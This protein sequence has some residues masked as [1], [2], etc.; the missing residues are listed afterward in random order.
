[1][2]RANTSAANQACKASMLPTSVISSPFDALNYKVYDVGSS[3]NKPYLFCKY[4]CFTS[5]FSVPY[6]WLTKLKAQLLEKI[7]FSVTFF[8]ASQYDKSVFCCNI[9]LIVIDNHRPTI[10]YPQATEC[11][12]SSNNFH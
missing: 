11:F 10:C 1:M 4:L 8:I 5:H 3:I 2:L 12:S 6:V 9:S 7:C